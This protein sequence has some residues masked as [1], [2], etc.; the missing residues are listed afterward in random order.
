MLIII[1][2]IAV[3]ALL[4]IYVVGKRRTPAGNSRPDE[5]RTPG[6]KPSANFHA[7]SIKF[8][9]KACDAAKEMAGRRFLSGTAPRIP[10]PNCDALECSCKF[11]HHQDRRSGD[12][13]RDA[14]GK[15]FG[16]DS[17]GSFEAEQRKVGDRR[18]DS[19]DDFFK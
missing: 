2:L 16:G 17:T 1:S 18:D 5:R 8:T 9:N 7:V 4:V 14:Y 15:G 11:V 6:A 13:R 19:P 10:L 3:A 12:D